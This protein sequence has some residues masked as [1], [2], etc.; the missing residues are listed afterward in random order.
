MLRDRHPDFAKIVDSLLKTAISTK[1]GS[2]P[3]E[4]PEPPTKNE[5]SSLL[6]LVKHCQ[7][8]LKVIQPFFFYVFYTWMS[9]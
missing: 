7:Y 8:V 1:R 2:R 3:Q 5:M 4:T 9:R 6:T